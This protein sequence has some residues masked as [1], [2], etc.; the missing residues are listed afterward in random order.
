MKESES[1][2]SESGDSSLSNASRRKR[3]SS[4]ERNEIRREQNRVAQK[5][6][7]ERK[8]KRLQELERLANSTAVILELGSRNNSSNENTSDTS[9]TQA[10]SINPSSITRGSVGPDASFLSPGVPTASQRRVDLN[11]SSLVYST[12]ATLE[13]ALQPNALFDG[14]HAGIGSLTG[15]IPSPTSFEEFLGESSAVDIDEITSNSLTDRISRVLSGDDNDAGNEYPEFSRTDAF[16]SSP[17]D[18]SGLGSQPRDE[19]LQTTVDDQHTPPETTSQRVIS[20]YRPSGLPYEILPSIIRAYFFQLPASLRERLQKMAKSK[21]FDFID[22]I[23]AEITNLTLGLLDSSHTSPDSS[24][25][26]S[27]SPHS[28]LSLHPHSPA[29]AKLSGLN[30]YI[31]NLAISRISYFASIFVNASGLGFD[32]GKFLDENCTSPIYDPDFTNASEAEFQALLETKYRTVAKDLR[33]VMAQVMKKHHPYLDVLPFPMFRQRAITAATT[34]PPLLDEDDL[35]I[36]LM[37]NDGLV[38]W[39]SPGGRASMDM[40]AP[41]DMRSWEAK[42]WFLKKWWW[43]VGDQDDVMWSGTR[44]WQMIRRMN[45]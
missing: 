27:S 21:Q 17:N 3:T 16:T 2:P 19:I 5:A 22:I 25:M 8:K 28:S 13:E 23:C 36:D 1:T 12:T 31:N 33:P 14:N 30:P 9:T 37:I 32:F 42:P 10:S 26:E 24:M 43:L 41:W 29:L 15:I 38:C 7:R 45:G 35:C 39:G 6:Y 4:K 11:Q 34:D 20:I 44:W 18:E 40:G